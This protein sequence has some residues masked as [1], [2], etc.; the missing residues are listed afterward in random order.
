MAPFSATK[1]VHHSSILQD[2]FCTFLLRKLCVCRRLF[3][4]KNGRRNRKLQNIP[5]GP[6]M[7]GD[8]ADQVKPIKV[9]DGAGK[10]DD[11]GEGRDF[12][13]EL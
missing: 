4:R 6:V 5:F 9:L 3:P 12:R 1:Y 10:M 11:A 8:E 7:D 13:R 2:A